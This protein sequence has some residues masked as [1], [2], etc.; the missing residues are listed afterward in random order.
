MFDLV[1]EI[2]CCS[3]LRK[4]PFVTLLIQKEPVSWSFVCPKRSR[5]TSC[6]IFNSLSMAVAAV[7]SLRVR[8][9][10]NKPFV[11]WAILVTFD[12]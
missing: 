4:W 7:L 9:V 5:R 6:L 10:T 3:A 2:I 8:S 1:R 12:P 11:F